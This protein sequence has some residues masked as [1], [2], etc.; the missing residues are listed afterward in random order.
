MAAHASEAFRLPTNVKPTHYDLTI[1]T[2]LE[3]EAFSG[4]VKISIEIVEPTT[5]IVLHSAEELVLN[6]ESLTITSVPGASAAQ[7]GRVQLTS[8]KTYDP[9]TQRVS[10]KLPTQLQ[11][12]SKAVLSITFNN[13]L[14]DSMVGYYKSQWP[15]GIYSLTQFESTDARRALPCW[16]EPLLKATFGVTM[17]SRAGTVSLA[18][19]GALSDAPNPSSLASDFSPSVAEA[20]YAGVD[21]GEWT[22][23]TFEN[24]PPMS[25]Y[26][27]AFANGPFEYIE[28]SYTSIKGNVRPLRIYAT[29]DVIGQCQFCLD[30]TVR[31]VPL[32]EKV[33]DV[34]Y[35]L[36]KL[37]TLVAHDFDA[38]AMENW[39]LITGRTSAVLVDPNSQD[40]TRQMAVAGTQSHEIAHMWFGDITTMAWWDNLYLNEGFATVMGESII[41]DRLFPEWRVNSQFINSN[42]NQ[43]LR[44]D[45]KLSSHPIEVPIP[46]PNQINQIFDSLSYAKAAS[47]LRMLS[48]YVGEKEFLKGVSVYLKKHSYKNTVS[49][50]LW[51]GVSEATG[52][53]VD[54]LMHNWVTAMGF[55]VLKVTE[56]A[57]GKSINVRQDRFLEDGEPSEKDNETIWTVPLALLSS[58]GLDRSAVLDKREATFEIDT[59]KPWKLNAGTAGVYRVLYTPE[60]LQKIAAQAAES[61]SPFA[62]EDR[63]GLVHDAM[64]LAKSGQL[65]ISAALGL[66]WTWRSEAEYLVWQGISD[67]LGIVVG[68]WQENSH[69]K[70]QL[71]AYR[72]A[73][74]VPLVQKLGYE[75]RSGESPDDT[76][77]RKVAVGVAAAAGDEGVLKELRTR[78]GKYIAGDEAAVPADLLGTTFA[79][80]V[81]HGG[82]EEYEAVLKLFEAGKNPSV[83]QASMR[84]LGSTQDPELIERTLG[85]IAT[86]SRNQD[87][88]YFFWGLSSN[89]KARLPLRD[90]FEKEYDTLYKRFETT[91]TFKYLISSTYAGF[92]SKKDLELAEKFFDG[93]DISKFNM[94]L[95]QAYDSI[96]A[97]L[98][99]IER[100][101][102]DLQSFLDEW[103]KEAGAKL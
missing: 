52:K 39:G 10:Y 26:L 85:L 71:D 83:H 7:T 22:A 50:D 23:T 18:N 14:T 70:S 48:E 56:S 35:P 20:L 100:S 34:E 51:A 86:K 69:I 38:G 92:S 46:D 21:K 41:L 84:A 89:L 30:V 44:L 74:Y 55:P 98:R 27:L 6:D 12:G 68:T 42:L 97:K 2:D 87:V 77:L 4:A 53:D 82:K 11:P 73:L 102:D 60:R 47:V 88:I 36:S 28:S 33:F 78:F 45:A 37:D 13:T 75:Y 5:Q 24:T 93:K 17:I 64:A 90:Y 3:K 66:V 9:V 91:S 103:E 8:G 81:K 96:K 58:K 19:T 16:D 25:T 72:R 62:L 32:Y 29:K 79:Q 94:A 63:I 15:G 61:G 43:A 65:K 57:D 95:A 40:L 1:R 67:N 31:A 99:W 49:S 54:A 101:T 80:S 59:A 76:Q